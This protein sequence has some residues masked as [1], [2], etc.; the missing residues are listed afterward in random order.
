MLAAWRVRSLLLMRSLVT[1]AAATSLVLLLAG[2]APSTSPAGDPPSAEPTAS[3]TAVPNGEPGSRLP[4]SCG[5]L[6]DNDAMT[7]LLGADFAEE[8]TETGPPRVPEATTVA[9]DQ[10]S[11]TECRWSSGT[12][13]TTGLSVSLVA[14]AEQDYLSWIASSPSTIEYPGSDPASFER[15]ATGVDQ[16]V[17]ESMAGGCHE[18]TGCWHIFG[19]NGYWVE[20]TFWAEPASLGAS[21]AALTATLAS[22]DATLHEVGALPEWRNPVSA[23]TSGARCPADLDPTGSL[24]AATGLANPV[25]LEAP[26]IGGSPGPE[27]LAHVLRSSGLVTCLQYDSSYDSMVGVEFVP[28][29]E[30]MWDAVV[31]LTPSAEQID[32]AGAEEARIL[33]EP[34]A[35]CRV[36]ALVEHTWVNVHFQGDAGTDAR[37][38]GIAAAQASVAIAAA[39]IAAS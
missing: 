8:A 34:V 25:P 7:A 19:S 1:V 15:P 17:G 3:S 6:A 27:A 23:P 13:G 5:E 24:A 38:A 29:S 32:V 35:T 10:S 31:E 18:E 21:A 26:G 28:G 36:Y 16:Q 33:C 9:I 14:Y 22:I 37:A 20:S 4:V 11:L 39:R 2:C 30:W 12:F